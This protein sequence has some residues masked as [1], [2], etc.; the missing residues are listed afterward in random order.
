MRATKNRNRSAAAQE[1]FDS[2]LGERERRGLGKEG[3][4]GTREEDRQTEGAI[5]GRLSQ[6]A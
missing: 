2:Q 5:S 6:V 3:K 1:A 4:K